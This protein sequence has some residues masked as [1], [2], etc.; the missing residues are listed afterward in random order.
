MSTQRHD[1][2]NP[3]VVGPPVDCLGR[4]VEIPSCLARGHVVIASLNRVLSYVAHLAASHLSLVVLEPDT[5]LGTGNPATTPDGSESQTVT[6]PSRCLDR[7]ATTLPG[8]DLP[9]EP[10]QNES[11]F[12]HSGHRSHFD[13]QEWSSLKPTN[14]GRGDPSAAASTG[15][16]PEYRV[17]CV[18]FSHVDEC[19]RF[20]YDLPRRCETVHPGSRSF[21]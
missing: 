6:P 20:V 21:P 1:A 17:H 4:D 2:G 16:G 5:L 7:F 14:V 13:L 8:D 19:N 11:I 12:D 15:S 18:R 10:A 9:H 3:P